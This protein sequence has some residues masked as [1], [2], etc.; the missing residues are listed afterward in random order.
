MSCS[1][2]E[3]HEVEKFL[4]LI[5]VEGFAPKP[6]LLTFHELMNKLYYQCV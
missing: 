4:V 5:E 1:V 6:W 3:I 2:D